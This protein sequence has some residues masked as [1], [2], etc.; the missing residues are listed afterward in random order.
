MA[1]KRKV[2]WAIDVAIVSELEKIA[3]RRGQSVSSVVNG[4]VAEALKTDD[5]LLSVLGKTD[6]MQAVLDLIRTPAFVA[7]VSDVLGKRRKGDE[8]AAMFDRMRK[9]ASGK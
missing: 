6:V 7:E 9:S 1:N 2:C 4:I 8:S 3:K 5:M